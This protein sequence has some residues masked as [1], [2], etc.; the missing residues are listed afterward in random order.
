MAQ[1]LAERMAYARQTGALR[2]ASS[3]GGRASF[4]AKARMPVL[5][6]HDQ[7]EA[8]ASA[9]ESLDE[10]EYSFREEQIRDGVDIHVPHLTEY[11]DHLSPMPSPYCTK[12]TTSMPDSPRGANGN[13]TSPARDLSRVFVSED[14]RV[15]LNSIA[16]GDPT[17]AG[18]DCSAF[19]EQ[20][21]MC[22]FMPEWVKRAGPHQSIYIDPQTTHAAVVSCGGLCPGINDV[23]RQIV[24]TLERGYG[25]QNITAIPYGFA[26]F[27]N[28]R[29]E[30]FPLSTRLVDQIQ[31]QGGTFLG[32]SRGGGDVPPIVDTIQREGINMLFVIGGN[33]SHAGANAIFEECSRRG[34]VCS[35]IAIPK[36]IDNDILYVDKT[37]GF[38]TCI[39]E[40]R[41]AISSAAIEAKSALR[42]VGLVK[43][44]GRQSGF[45]AMHAALA[46]GEVDVCLIPEVGF[47][48]EGD[49]GLLEH[50]RYL[51]DTQGNAVVVV[52]EGV[53]QEIVG[54]GGVDA[55]G[56]PLLSDFGKYLASRVKSDLSADCKYIDPTY[57]VRCLPAN[58]HDSVYCTI[59]G[60]NAVHAAFAGYTGCSIG[61]CNTHYVFLPIS[62]VIQQT[63]SVD[64]NGRMWNRLL[65]STGQPEFY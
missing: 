43:L 27:T 24:T 63:R 53:G 3:Q 28:E 55:S 61:L 48:L 10:A 58:A 40:A 33:G 44:M 29:L 37:F 51:L 25:V 12:S 19:D 36:T 62:L 31:V 65:A 21:R 11:F 59:L 46:S 56:N 2:P 20:T 49:N 39:E 35:V 18:A 17:S 7:D 30:T 34:V 4:G 47:K 1:Q 9:T 23:V 32:T 54:E 60:Q 57:M 42:G 41:R 26:G 64:A 5:R 8:F 50:I 52:A 14:D 15:V 13:G 38:D 22:E 6:A 16:Y 45:I